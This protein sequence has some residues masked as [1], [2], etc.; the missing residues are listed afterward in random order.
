M[1]NKTSR[2]GCSNVIRQAGP[3]ILLNLVL[4]RSKYSMIT[5]ANFSTHVLEIALR[6]L[7]NV[8]LA[9]EF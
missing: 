7:Q 2:E 4:A 5:L 6:K 8:I 9:I 1:V 3:H